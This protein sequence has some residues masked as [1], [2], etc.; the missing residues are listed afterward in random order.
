MNTLRTPSEA[1]PSSSRSQTPTPMPPD[2]S[3][4]R[5]PDESRALAFQV[6]KEV[7]DEFN[8]W[9]VENC[10]QQL[11]LLQKPLPP[12]AAAEDALLE[13]SNLRDGEPGEVE[14]IYLCDSEDDIPH[15]P[16]GSTVLMCETVHLELPT[17]FTPHPRYESCTPAVQS[18]VLHVG[19]AAGEELVILPFVP[20]ADDPTFDAEAYLGVHNRFA[21]EELGDPD[22]EV[23][24][25]ET[26]RRLSTGNRLSLDEIDATSVLPPL[27][28]SNREGL[29]YSMTQRD[30]LFW[31]GMMADFPVDTDGVEQRR[32][33]PRAHEPDIN[34]LRGRLDSVFPYFCAN[35]GCIQ[36]FCPRHGWDFPPVPPTAPRVT[37]DDY[38]EGESCGSMCF[39]EID[40]TFG[41]DNVEWMESDVDELQCIL[42]VIPDTLPCGLAILVR[43]P[44]REVYVQ[45]QRLITDDKVYPESAQTLSSNK[46]KYS[47]SFH[48]RSMILIYYHLVVDKRKDKSEN[49]EYYLAPGPCSHTGPCDQTN[50]GCTCAEESVHCLRNCRCDLTCQRRS[51]GC[52]C[53]P[54]LTTDMPRSQTCSEITCP[55]RKKGWECDPSICECDNLTFVRSR[56]KWPKNEKPLPRRIAPDKS[57]YCQNSDIQRG[58]VAEVEIKRGAYGLGAFAAKPILENQFIGEYVGELVPSDLDNR[59]PLRNHV[60]LNYNFGYNP[61]FNLDSARVGNETRYI[62]HGSGGEKGTANSVGQTRL[63]FGE[64]RI[65]LWATRYIKKGEEILFDYGDNYWKSKNPGVLS[66]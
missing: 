52:R 58:L 46:I 37:S 54:K 18:M 62:N 28:L 59:E 29:I 34:D 40:D 44:C 53:K 31:P 1:G 6:Y 42:E 39:R 41:E 65:G 16:G 64:Q 50:P 63:V 13:V 22:V 25:F 43:K 9:K 30:E 14:I 21:W 23:I 61:T 57:Y 35:P 4:T 26:L 49:F 11:L 27:R 33:D 8:K 66:T 24:Q 2:L 36:A 3:L 55:C 7:W 17:D 20:Y 48:G 56:K 47:T 51:K 45:R 32:I 12:P 38:P 60:D 10:K 5:D 15:H 19:S